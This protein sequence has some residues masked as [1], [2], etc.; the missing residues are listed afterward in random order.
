MSLWVIIRISDWT[1]VSSL[2]AQNPAKHPSFPLS[3]L[4]V[5]LGQK[6]Q[7]A[8]RPLPPLWPAFSKKSTR[9]SFGV[10]PLFSPCPQT[11][12][13]FLAENENFNCTRVF[14]ITPFFELSL[15]LL[16]THAIGLYEV[17]KKF[18]RY[19]ARALRAL[20]LLLADGTPTV[21]G[22][23]T[24]WAVSQIFLRKQL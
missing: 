13:S 5:H 19:Q 14:H 22:G 9:D 7:F 10:R 11:P 18:Q 20:G 8:V 12:L 15:V 21:G 16:T 6:R 23:K 17:T 24:F 4:V 3:L 1:Q 2:G